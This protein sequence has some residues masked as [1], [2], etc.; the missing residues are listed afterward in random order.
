MKTVDE[1]IEHY[2]KCGQLD[3]DVDYIKVGW[4]DDMKRRL[5]ETVVRSFAGFIISELKK[6]LRSAS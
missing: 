1:F 2:K 6:E 5:L 3:I 4:D